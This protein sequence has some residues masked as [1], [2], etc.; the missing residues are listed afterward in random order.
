MIFEVDYNEK[1]GWKSPRISGFHKLE[2]DPRNSVLHYAVQTFEGI[3]VRRN[4]NQENKIMMFRPD[5]HIQR[6][7]NSADRLGFPVKYNYLIK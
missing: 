4:Q 3:S 1:T 5:C 6:L 7:K 2:I